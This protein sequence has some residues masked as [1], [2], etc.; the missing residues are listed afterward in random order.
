MINQ[1]RVWASADEATYGPMPDFAANPDGWNRRITIRIVALCKRHGIALKDTQKAILAESVHA[2][3]SLDKLGDTDVTLVQAA[4]VIR[5]RKATTR[6]HQRA[7]AGLSA[8]AGSLGLPPTNIKVSGIIRDYAVKI[9]P[10]DVAGGKAALDALAAKSRHA[11]TKPVPSELDNY[12]PRNTNEPAKEDEMTDNTK[13][14]TAR[15][16]AQLWPQLYEVYDTFDVTD[17]RPKS[18][19]IHDLLGVESLS[20]FPADVTDAEIVNRLYAEL[21]RRY[22]SRQIPGSVANMPDE[23]PSTLE[24]HAYALETP[25]VESTRQNE[26]NPAN[27]AATGGY[28]EQTPFVVLLDLH[29]ASGIA[30]RFTVRAWSAE[31]LLERVEDLTATFGAKGFTSQRPASAQAHDNTNG[32]G[33]AYQAPADERGGLAPCVLIEIGS[34]YT[35]G[36]P[37]LN[38]VIDGMEHPLRFTRP[39]QMVKMLSKVRKSNGEAFTGSDLVIGRK[40]AGNWSVKWQQGEKYRDV[41]DVV[42]A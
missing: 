18:A 26:G 24:A 9:D 6:R 29:H 12:F 42:P 4:V 15:V 3:A 1:R 39:D 30:L 11:P 19:V 25:I 22:K 41:L 21:E 20:D 33:A 23:R 2:A 10:P 31:Q 16:W 35:G 32:N 17:K 37:Q 28:T 5:R 7:I 13:Q 38:F 40:F 8:Y 34:S 36:K 14:Q 27:V